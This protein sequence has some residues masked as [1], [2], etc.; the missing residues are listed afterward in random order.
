MKLNDGIKEKILNVSMTLMMRSGYRKVTMDEIAQGLMMSKN[1]IYKYFPSKEDI[2]QGLFSGLKDQINQE[3][4][5]IEEAHP[6]SLEVIS[7]SV[8]FIQKQLGPW[9][10]H[11][12][13][14]IKIEVPLLYEDFTKFRNEKIQNIREQIQKGIKAGAFRNVHPSVAV[15]VY[16][17]AID[18][19]LNPEFLREER[20]SF[21]EA[22][23]SVMDIWSS[24]ILN[25]GSAKEGG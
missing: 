25:K 17:G 2:A 24:G 1:T 10:E 7:K 18:Q 12:L 4:H 9:F 11:F 3:L 14:D 23:E 6:D 19:V 8:F 13:G 20:I 22:I 5:L 21:P 16:L 15:G